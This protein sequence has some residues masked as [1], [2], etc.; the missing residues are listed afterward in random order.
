MLNPSR[1]VK[2]LSE[3]F[4]VRLR[5]TQNDNIMKQLLRKTIDQSFKIHMAHVY[6]D[7]QGVESTK[8]VGL[9]A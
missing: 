7:K 6:R 1:R 3:R 4:F 9:V 2:H 8:P 5:W